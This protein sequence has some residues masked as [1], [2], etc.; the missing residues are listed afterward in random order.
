MHVLLIGAVLNPSWAGGEPRIA[1]L[2]ASS[3]SDRKIEV[4]NLF[5]ERTIPEKLTYLISHMHVRGSFEKCYSFMIPEIDNSCVKHYLNEIER[6]RPDIVMTWYDYDVSAFWAGILSRKPTIVQAEIFWPLCPK[7]DLFNTLTESPCD[8][9]N[10]YCGPCI[11]E[12]K[13]LKLS[14]LI[15]SIIENYKIKRF[16]SKLCH[17]SAIITDSY[18]LKNRM[19]M[20]GYPDQ[21]IH[22]IYNGVSIEEIEPFPPDRHEKTVLFLSGPDKLKGTEHFM[23]LSKNLKPEFPDVR[24]LW[25]GQT[26][27]KGETFEVQDY[28]WNEKQLN[29]IY[30]AAYL[31]LLPSLWPEPMSYTVLEAMA[32]GKPVVAYDVGANNEEIIHGKTGFLARWGDIKQLQSYVKELLLDKALAEQMGRDARKFI[33][34][35]FSLKRMTYN[36]VHLLDEI[37]SKHQR[38]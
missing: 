25:V 21:L 7:L 1:R 29:E 26:K 9:P 11:A 16:K 24:F 5:L 2:L 35:K 38:Q 13:K 37:W 17:A 6:I 30:R 15:L 10:I 19:M 23:R 12:E 32:H 4:S 31:V 3:L 8:G 18:Y 27:I 22:V 33:E 36:Y 14:S 28:V 34:S 20:R